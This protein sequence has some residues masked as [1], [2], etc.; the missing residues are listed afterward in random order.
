MVDL[1]L[2]LLL[3]EYF[4]FFFLSG[5]RGGGRIRAGNTRNRMPE[6]LNAHERRLQG[7]EGALGVGGSWKSFHTKIAQKSDIDRWREHVLEGPETG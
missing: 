4:P 1:L 5:A 7:F 6:C 3:Y 2:L